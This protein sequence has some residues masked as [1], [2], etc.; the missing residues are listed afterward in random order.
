MGI[1]DSSVVYFV[2]NCCA[3]STIDGSTGALTWDVCCCATSPLA[4]SIYTCVQIVAERT[5]RSEHIDLHDCDWNL[6]R[7][8]FFAWS[9]FERR[10]CFITA[11]IESESSS[12]SRDDGDGK[13][14]YSKH[15]PWGR[16]NY[17][18]VTRL[19]KQERYRSWEDIKSNNFLSVYILYSLITLFSFQIN[20]LVYFFHCVF[21]SRFPLP[22]Y[23]CRVQ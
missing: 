22:I 6:Q 13:A 10:D 11:R 15:V 3:S 2:R 8:Q 7:F 20:F 18:G 17:H 12:L 9:W 5:V 16:S 23:G 19:Y 4:A 21:Y 14:Q 1:R